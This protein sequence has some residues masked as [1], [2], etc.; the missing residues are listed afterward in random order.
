[1]KKPSKMFWEQTDKMR[2][3]AKEHARGPEFF[4][5]YWETKKGH[6]ELIYPDFDD[7]K[8]WNCYLTVKCLD[9]GHEFM[10]K[11]GFWLVINNGCGCD[12]CNRTESIDRSVKLLESKGFDV[13]DTSTTEKGTRIYKIKCRKC[14]ENFRKKRSNFSGWLAHGAKCPICLGKSFPPDVMKIRKLHNKFGI[15]YKELSERAHYAYA[16]V[17][18]IARGVKGADETVKLLADVAEEMAK[19]KSK[20]DDLD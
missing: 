11:A 6:W 14:G 20:D 16:F 7:I 17:M 2:Q 4:R 10:R 13:L 15:T 1:M 19:E 12:N 3:V 5:P 8:G 18:D 9:C